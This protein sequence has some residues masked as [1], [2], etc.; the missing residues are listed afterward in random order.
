M[1]R[2]GVAWRRRSLYDSRL[3]R[4]VGDDAG[5]RSSGSVVRLG[6]A[7]GEGHRERSAARP[8]LAKRSLIAIFI[9][10]RTIGDDDTLFENR[11]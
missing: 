3:P 9:A 7:V 2:V 4:T 11:M 8:P 1:R 6:G 10:P 5:S